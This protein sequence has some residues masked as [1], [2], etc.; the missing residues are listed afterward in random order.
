M[1]RVFS[2]VVLALIGFVSTGCAPSSFVRTPGGWKTVEIRSGLSSNYDQAWQTTV[3]TVARNWDIEILDKDSGYL[4]TTWVTGI[5]GTRGSVA[6]RYSGRITIKYP[7]VLSP[8]KVEVKTEARWQEEY[9]WVNGYD[10]QFERDVFSA[11]SG[12]LGR[13]VPTN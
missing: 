1:N 7:S 4:R 13:T 9:G 8:S 2:L 11:L 6:Q 12:R 5:V 10:T 3:D